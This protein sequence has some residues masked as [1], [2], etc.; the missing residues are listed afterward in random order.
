MAQ[1]G[2][3]MT[4]VVTPKVLDRLKEEDEARLNKIIHLENV[5]F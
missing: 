1:S 3:E 2:K 4:F 5:T